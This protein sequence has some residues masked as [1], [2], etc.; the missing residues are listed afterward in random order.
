MPSRVTAPLVGR[1]PVSACVADAEQAARSSQHCFVD[2]LAAGTGRRSLL[3]AAAPEAAAT[4]P[5]LLRHFI[6]NR[7]EHVGDLVS[8]TA[9][10][11][12]SRRMRAAGH[13]EPTLARRRRP[14]GRRPA[15]GL[16][17]EDMGDPLREA[18]L[19]APTPRSA[20]SL[21]TRDASC[22]FRSRMD[23]CASSR[24]ASCS[25]SASS[26]RCSFRST[27]ARGAGNRPPSS[28]FPP[29]RLRTVTYSIIL[30]LRAGDSLTKTQH[31]LR[32]VTYSQ[33]SSS[34]ATLSDQNTSLARAITY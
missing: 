28:S 22:S 19:R 15:R 26:R 3:G 2:V 8:K 24:A 16:P 33:Y 30:F 25:S 7:L 9:P 10:A 13:T 32:K 18:T 6:G 17:P 14:L 11:A 4:L 1:A 5:L 20:A 34:A 29:Q 21:A 27:C 23:R 31:I 12:P